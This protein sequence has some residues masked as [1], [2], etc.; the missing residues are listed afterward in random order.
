MVVV[1]VTVL[2]E[3]DLKWIKDDGNEGNEDYLVPGVQPFVG[4]M[5]PPGYLP[6]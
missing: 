2:L 3:L 1:L 6:G 5:N 4:L